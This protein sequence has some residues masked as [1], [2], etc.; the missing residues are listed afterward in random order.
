MSTAVAALPI[1]VIWVMGAALLM[2]LV[3]TPLSYLWQTRVA[4]LAV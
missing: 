3:I 1:P 2:E 4:R